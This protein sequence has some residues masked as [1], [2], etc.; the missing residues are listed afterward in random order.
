V[1][2]PTPQVCRRARGRQD[3]AFGG[4]NGPVLTVAALAGARIERPRRENAPQGPNS[5]IELGQV[6]CFGKSHQFAGRTHSQ[7]M[8]GLGK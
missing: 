5:R 2:V 7:I 4:P 6:S 3:R 8:L 1:L